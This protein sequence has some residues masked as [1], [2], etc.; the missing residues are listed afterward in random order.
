MDRNAAYTGM[1]QQLL[2]STAE[3]ISANEIEIFI[4]LIA[5]GITVSDAGV[6]AFGTSIALPASAIT[7]GTLAVARGGTNLGS[8]SVGDLVYA[9]ASTVLAKLAA[10]A[11]GKVLISGGTTT[12][13]SWGQVANAHVSASA[14]IAYSK[15][16]LSDSVVNAD[17]ASAAAIAF[18]KL[19]DGTALSVLGVTGNSGAANASIVAG[20]DHNVLRRSGTAVAFGAVNLAQSGAVTGNLAVGN[21][22]G[23]TNASSSTFWRGDGS[24]VTPS[25]GAAVSGTPADSQ[26][27]VW[28]NSTTIEG[29]ST[30]TFD[31]TTFTTPGQIKFPAS[32]SASSDANTLDDYEEGTWTPVIGGTG[33]QSGQN[34]NTQDGDYVKIGKMVLVSCYVALS[35]EGTITGNAMITGLPFTMLGGAGGETN[36]SAAVYWRDLA[37]NWVS[38][39]ANGQGST[40]Y[41]LTGATAAA[42]SNITALTA[43]DIGNDTRFKLSGVYQATA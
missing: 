5:S 26:V 21:L 18:S 36:N 27:A 12:A 19:A 2:S 9:S 41:R 33:G 14:A 23:G 25:G 4:R 31:G 32:Q 10:V 20:S 8:Y 40:N 42:A 1:M 7:S 17:V 38:I 15:L 30:F 16:A 11:T 3:E 22:N 37:T 29:G 43:S 24:W 35:T 13:P 34:Y 39:V 28:T 6:I